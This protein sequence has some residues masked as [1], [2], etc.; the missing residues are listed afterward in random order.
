[1]NITTETRWNPFR[2]HALGSSVEEVNEP[3]PLGAKSKTWTTT[4]DRIPSWP[5]EAKPLKKR[6]G[7]SYLF[8]IGDLILVLL[9]IYFI[10]RSFKVISRMLMLIAISP[11][12]CG[13]DLKW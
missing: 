10:R 1:M 13:S 4:V 5:E 11:R 6:N 7:L 2:R 8:G 9:P 12:G 3:A